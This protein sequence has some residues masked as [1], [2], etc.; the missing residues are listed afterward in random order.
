M[1]ARV[2]RFFRKSMRVG[3]A[4]LFGVA[5]PMRKVSNIFS[6]LLLIRCLALSVWGIVLH[7]CFVPVLLIRCLAPQIWG[8]FHM[9][10]LRTC[11]MCKVPHTSST[12]SGE[13]LLYQD[14]LIR[15]TPSPLTREVGSLMFFSEVDARWNCNSFRT[16]A[17]TAQEAFWHSPCLKAGDSRFAD[18]S[19]PNRWVF[20]S[21]HERIGSG[22]SRP[23]VGIIYTSR[24]NPSLLKQGVLRH[25][26]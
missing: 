25:L 24:R 13:W 6:H 18:R 3:I 5:Q 14:K 4:I 15:N 12:G 11:V 26:W 20:H 9:P 17:A 1:D 8:S 22:V 21:L 19:P 7:W 2:F 10:L 23:T 16:C